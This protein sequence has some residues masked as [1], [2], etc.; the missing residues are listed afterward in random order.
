MDSSRPL[1]VGWFPAGRGRVQDEAVRRV[2]DKGCT[3][4][5]G[6]ALVDPKPV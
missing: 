2:L 6:A 4:D 1:T 3:A 5:E